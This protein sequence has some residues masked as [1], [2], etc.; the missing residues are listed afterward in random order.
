MKRLPDVG[1]RVLTEM[2]EGRVRSINMISETLMVE[3]ND[4]IRKHDASDIL[5]ILDR[6]VKKEE[7]AIDPDQLKELID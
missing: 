1:N 5:K 4:I 7:I 2:G 3:Y 6:K